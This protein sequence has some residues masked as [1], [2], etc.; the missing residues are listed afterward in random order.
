MTPL[1]TMKN[2]ISR[3]RYNSFSYFLIM[4]CVVLQN[5]QFLII[6]FSDCMKLNLSGAFGT[7]YYWKNRFV[8]L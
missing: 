3:E 5:V 8:L 7:K 6:G 2:R 1:K 4:I